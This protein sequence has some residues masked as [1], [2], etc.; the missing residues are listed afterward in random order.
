M[1]TK[2]PTRSRAHVDALLREISGS[3]YGLIDVPT[4]AARGIARNSINRRVHEGALLRL[5]RGVYRFAGT[6]STDRQRLAAARLAAGSD[7]VLVGRSAAFLHGLDAQLAYDVGVPPNRSPRIVGVSV[8]RLLLPS[9]EKTDVASL[10]TTT[11]SRTV[12]DLAGCT[13]H[14]KLSRVVDDVL[15]K[16]LAT[17]EELLALLDAHPRHIGAPAVRCLLGDRTSGTARFRSA[18][19]RQIFGHLRSSGLGDGLP[20]FA[21][22]DADG[23]KRILDQAWPRS[24]VAL[25]YDSFR[26]HTGRK[27]WAADVQR[28]NA[29]TSIGWRMV[30][31]T[32]AD[33][34]DH[35]RKP[36][37]ALNLLLDR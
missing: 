14:E 18:A 26:W 34:A 3:Q 28:R 37:S 25:E 30:S 2:F 5:H 20:N 31:A 19:E 17:R 12:L 4:A 15:A 10:S 22:L 11:I 6:E 13:T 21:V 16:R 7:A 35:L 33:L 23:N 9:C 32:D 1:S 27:N 36:I 8:H 24:M 29:L